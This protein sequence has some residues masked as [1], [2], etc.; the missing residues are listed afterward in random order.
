MGR[1]RLLRAYVLVQRENAVGRAK[2][3]WRVVGSWC[4]SRRGAE[5]MLQVL[6]GC[7]RGWGWRRLVRLVGWER[8]R[9]MG[10]MQRACRRRWG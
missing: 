1:A 5:E 2:Q 9:H 8:W 4:A 3:G 10:R 7:R 6:H